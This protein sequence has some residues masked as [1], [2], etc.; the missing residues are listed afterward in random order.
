MVLV[1]ATGLFA[2]ANLSGIDA[3][4]Y[5]A[6]MIFAHVGFGGTYGADPGDGWASAPSTWSQPSS[7]WP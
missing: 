7:P 3:I 6:P 1:L 2:F 5:Y 4:L